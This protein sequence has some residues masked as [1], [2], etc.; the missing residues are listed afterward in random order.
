MKSLLCAV[1]AGAS[2]QAPGSI[3]C[4]AESLNTNIAQIG[5]RSVSAGRGLSERVTE[6][7]LMFRGPFQGFYRSYARI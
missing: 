5:L 4:C 6:D 7:P 2:I 3:S 1:V